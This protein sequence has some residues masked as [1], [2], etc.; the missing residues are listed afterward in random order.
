MVGHTEESCL[1]G[2]FRSSCC[3]AITLIEIES[4]VKLTLSGHFTHHGSISD[5]SSSEYAT[6]NFP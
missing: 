1:R 2:V 3:Y 6:R 4:V 5:N